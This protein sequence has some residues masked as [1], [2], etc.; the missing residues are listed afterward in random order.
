MALANVT[1]SKRN[2]IL[3]KID[4]RISLISSLK[5][6]QKLTIVLKEPRLGGKAIT[7]GKEMF[8]KN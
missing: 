8:S 4:C 5:N 6:R 7:K 3:K 1:M 2:Q